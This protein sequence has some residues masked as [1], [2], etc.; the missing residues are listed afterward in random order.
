MPC[1]WI[2]FLPDLYPN[3]RQFLCVYISFRMHSR[4]HEISYRDSWIMIDYPEKDNIFGTMHFIVL[5]L[6]C[7]TQIFDFTCTLLFFHSFLSRDLIN[8]SMLLILVFNL[9]FTLIL[10][11]QLS[12]YVDSG[13]ST[14]WMLTISPALS[15]QTRYCDSLLDDNDVGLVGRR[16]G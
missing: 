10:L 1:H 12:K 8:L 4:L 2:L 3:C 15:W 13:P 6:H 16:L 9:F 7:S 11:F 14:H 5:P